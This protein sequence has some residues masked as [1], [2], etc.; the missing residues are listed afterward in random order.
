M[1][2]LLIFLISPEDLH[3]TAGHS[4]PPD[5]DAIEVDKRRADIKRRE[6]IKEKARTT[7]NRPALLLTDA[8][9]SADPKLRPQLNKKEAI[10]RSIQRVRRGDLPKESSSTQV[11]HLFI[12]QHSNKQCNN[13]VH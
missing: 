5:N 4:H 2:I 8:V 6:D 10:K 1:Y 13:Q 9:S 3:V 11:I 7:K 12:V